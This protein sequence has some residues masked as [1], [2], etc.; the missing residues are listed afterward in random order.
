MKL[1]A[2]SIQLDSKGF[3]VP[4]K[5]SLTLIPYYAWAHRGSGD[6]SVWLPQ[7]LSAV[8]PEKNK[9]GISK[10]EI[11]GSH[12]TKALGF[13]CD[14]LVPTDTYDRSFPY[15]QWWPKKGGTEWIS[16]EYEN[17]K[18]VS[19]SSVYWYDDGPWGGCRLPKNWKLYYKD[20][21]GNWNPI[22]NS[23]PYPIY[24]GVR[25]KVFFEPVITK[26]LKLEVTL[27]DDNSA[28]IYEWEIE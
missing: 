12:K 1:D 21:S 8:R 19:S 14:N 3:L 28:G 4:H 9:S 22:K 2:Q 15:Y 13:I 24:K 10:V 7:E 18:K 17:P 16:Y 6:M 27:P 23:I 20:M 5:V 25:N 11:D 26:A